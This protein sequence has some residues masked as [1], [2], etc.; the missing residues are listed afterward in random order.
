MRPKI[1]V[2][3]DLVSI[4]D[5]VRIASEV[6]GYVDYLE[7]GT[8]LIKAEGLRAVSRLKEEFGDKVVV[9]DM[10]TM[11]TGYLEASLAFR[12]GADFSTVMGVADIVTIESSIVAAR[13]FGK[14]IMVDL[15][16][17]D[18]PLLIKRIASLSPEYLLVHSGIDMQHRGLMP[19]EPVGRLVDLGLGCKIGVA[20]GLNIDNIVNL[21]GLDIDLVIVGGYLTKAE[22]PGLAAKRLFEVIES[23]F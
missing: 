8:P 22:S 11:D 16:G 4:E 20:G 3:L 6:C 9:A 23:V 19:F 7:A 10:K 2:A 17:V 15:M 18:D 1:Q 14:G 5:A 13:D 21:R 12:Y